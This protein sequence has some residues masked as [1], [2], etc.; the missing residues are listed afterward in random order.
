VFRKIEIRVLTSFWQWHPLC[1][2]QK[3]WDHQSSRV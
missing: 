2:G 3:M 1:F